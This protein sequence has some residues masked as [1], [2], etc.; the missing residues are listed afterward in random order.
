[1]NLRS[2]QA[3]DQFYLNLLR[4]KRTYEVGSTFSFLREL[5]LT[6]SLFNIVFLTSCFSHRV[7]CVKTTGNKA[8]GGEAKG[9]S[10]SRWSSLS[11]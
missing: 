5:F 7:E 11:W 1:M 10:W 3:H 9:I 8:P 2:R 6:S 4:M